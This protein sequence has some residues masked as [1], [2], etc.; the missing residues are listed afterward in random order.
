MEE[1][2]LALPANSFSRNQ[3]F[4]PWWKLNYILNSDFENIRTHFPN[5]TIE[6]IQMLAIGFMPKIG[7]VSQLAASFFK[8]FR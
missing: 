1:I 5:A 2:G 6:T 8:E 3:C 4:Y 7:I